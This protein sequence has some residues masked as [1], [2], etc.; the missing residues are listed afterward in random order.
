MMDI[1]TKP[2]FVLVK[3]IGLYDLSLKNI[4]KYIIR[5]RNDKGHE[6]GIHNVTVFDH[7]CLGSKGKDTVKIVSSQMMSSNP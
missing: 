4:F 6:R 1:K 3:C 5:K 7:K 2:T